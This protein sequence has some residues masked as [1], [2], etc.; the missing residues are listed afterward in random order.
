MRVAPAISLSE[1][2][3]LRLEKL[4]RGRS[5]PLRVVQRSRIVL[6]AA[7]GLQNKQIADRMDVAP[8]MVALWR[9]RFLALGVDG[10]LRDA[11]R[12]GRTPSIS[13]QTVSQIIERTTQSRPVNATHWSRSIMAREA[14]ISVSSVGRI[15]RTHGNRYCALIVPATSALLTSALTFARSECSCLEF[16]VSDSGSKRHETT[17]QARRSQLPP[18]AEE[19]LVHCNG[20]FRTRRT[21]D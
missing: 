21:M 6:L 15:W 18:K 2:T 11:S 1:E 5:T 9:D 19:L 4:A 3:R 10:L 12:P 13:T 17:T 8:R 7:D 14:G 16:S 20:A